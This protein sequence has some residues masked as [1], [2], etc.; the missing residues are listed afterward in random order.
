M[1]SPAVQKKRRLV[2]LAL[3]KE[4]RR[5]LLASFRGWREPEERRARGDDEAVFVP[6]NEERKRS[7]YFLQLVGKD[8]RLYH[9]VTPDI[10]G[11]HLTSKTSWSAP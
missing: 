1:G 9:L 2:D 7:Q 10:F 3:V 5:H 8:R 4:D 6:G 11:A